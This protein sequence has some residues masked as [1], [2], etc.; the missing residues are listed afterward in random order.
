[1]QK[2]V[3]STAGVPVFV[4]SEDGGSDY[5]ASR[6][7]RAD[8]RR[9][10]DLRAGLCHLARRRTGF[11]RLRISPK[12][13]IVVSEADEPVFVVSNVRR[14]YFIV[15]ANSAPDVV[16][17]AVTF[18]KLCRIAIVSRQ[19]LVG[20]TSSSRRRHVKLSSASRQALVS[21]TSSSRRRHVKFSLA[22]G[23]SRKGVRRCD[24]YVRGV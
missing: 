6:S 17:A 3:A 14:P 20:V 23:N 15:S 13:K 18:S 4:I 16:A 22:D 12:P 7:P 2:I 10:R 11:H 9:L 8:N 21:V 1:M 5:I 19:A 24:V